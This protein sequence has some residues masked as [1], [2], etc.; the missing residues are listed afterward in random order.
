MV[1]K[2]AQLGAGSQYLASV[3]YYTLSFVIMLSFFHCMDM[4]GPPTWVLQSAAFLCS[5]DRMYLPKLHNERCVQFTIILQQCVWPCVYSSSCQAIYS[6]KPLWCQQ[7]IEGLKG[8]V[9]K[10]D[11]VQNIVAART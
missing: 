8:Q 1:V 4:R 5:L 6:F 10:A 2:H 9:I 11:Q 7:L 3:E